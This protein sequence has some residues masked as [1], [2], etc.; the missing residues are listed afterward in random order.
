MDPLDGG[1][2]LGPQEGVYS[3]PCLG[4][5]EGGARHR[6]CPIEVGQGGPKDQLPAGRDNEEEYGVAQ[7]PLP[8]A[9][10]SVVGSPGPG[11][12]RSTEIGFCC[13]ARGW[14]AEGQGTRW[15]PGVILHT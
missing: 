6:R 1:D 10:P 14:P 3:V 15:A 9:L 8:E 7:P 12:G 11:E 5:R 2:L 13:E 4:C